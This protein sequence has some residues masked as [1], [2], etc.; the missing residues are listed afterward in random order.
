ME[1]SFS[2]GSLPYTCPYCEAH[3]LKPFGHSSARCKDCGGE[4]SGALLQTLRCI[5]DL[6]DAFGRHACDCGH[7]EMRRL[8]DGVYR[9]PA[10]GS[11]VIPVGS[12]HREP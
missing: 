5:T 10:C 8:P 9:C 1:D 7:P 12:Y 11:E 2:K 3:E 4:L 6:P